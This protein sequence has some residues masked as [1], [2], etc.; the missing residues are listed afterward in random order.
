MID[1]NI[2]K[3]I[4]YVALS[5]LAIPSFFCLTANAQTPKNGVEGTGP[6][7]SRMNDGRMTCFK[8]A[9]EVYKA[10]V[11][12]TADGHPDL[13]GMW[14]GTANAN[15]GGLTITFLARDGNFVNFERD[16]TV[17][18]RMNQNRPLYKAQYWD[19]VHELDEEGNDSDPQ[20]RGMP[21]GVPRMGPPIKIIQMPG[22]TVLFYNNPD[23]Y[24]VIPTDGRPHTPDDKLEGTWR[25]EPLGH[26]EG[27]TFVIDS[28]GFNS[29][30]W[31]CIEGCIHSEN[32][33]V[34]E[35]FTRTGNTM[36]YA[37]TVEDPDMFMQPWQMDT[38]TMV[39]NTNPKA[40]PDES[41]PYQE[42]DVSHF[43]TK[44]H[45]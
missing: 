41:L 22:E 8:V 37:V 15:N 36:A 18:R 2:H 42:R 30:S 11:P 25:G 1:R 39:A 32:M 9:P 44:E 24:R 38:V 31:I 14:N 3:L 16:Y 13:S 19:T 4:K 21:E 28:V 6:C 7:P 35:R 45:H 23:T 26:W 34:I 33:H 5:A 27:D 12:R 29:S 40:V 43:V 20:F 10:P 17:L